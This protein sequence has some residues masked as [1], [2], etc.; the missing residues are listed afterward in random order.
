M[1]RTLVNY[2]FTPPKITKTFLQTLLSLPLSRYEVRA[3]SGNVY[4]KNRTTGER[5]LK[6]EAATQMVPRP[7]KLAHHEPAYQSLFQ[8]GAV[9]PGRQ[10]SEDQ[11]ARRF[12]KTTSS[13]RSRSRSPNHM[14]G[15]PGAYLPKYAS[16]VARRGKSSE[17][18]V[19][20][21]H[22]VLP[23]PPT[24]EDPPRSVQ[25]SPRRR[26]VCFVVDFFPVSHMILISM[27]THNKRSSVL[28]TEL[29]RRLSLSNNNQNKR[30]YKEE[31]KK[32]RKNRQEKNK[33]ILTK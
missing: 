14:F 28:F 10:R 7:R 19:R 23:S 2:Y 24:Y 13:G 20:H 5:L 21:I 22:E 30:K 25:S 6:R 3:P 12:S 29:D 33:E 18:V 9:L 27:D 4:L 16:G 32:C 15:M 11:D 8:T 31:N 26:K 1:L 17:R